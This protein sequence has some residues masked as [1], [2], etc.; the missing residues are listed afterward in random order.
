[1]SLFE[2]L[3]A[4]SRWFFVK[5]ALLE[6]KLNSCTLSLILTFDAFYVNIS[7][8]VSHITSKTLSLNPVNK[9]NLQKKDFVWHFLKFWKLNLDILLLTQDYLNISWLKVKQSWYFFDIDVFIH[10]CKHISQ[11]HHLRNLTVKSSI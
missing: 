7:L 5:T 4:Q 10:S 11:S 3:S 6:L 8:K 1:M 9:T 2:V